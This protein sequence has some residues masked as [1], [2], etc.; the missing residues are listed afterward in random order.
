AGGAVVNRPEQ[1]GGL[2]EILERQ[3][4]E[5]RFAG[6]TAPHLLA[7]RGVV[8]VALADRVVEDG[9]VRRQTRDRELVDVAFERAGGQQ[10]PCDVGEPQPLAEFM[11]LLGGLHWR[12][13]IDF[14]IALA[15][16]RRESSR[17][18]NRR[19]RADPPTTSDGPIA[20][21]LQQPP[22]RARTRTCA[23]DP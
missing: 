5:Q 9:R 23:A 13:S 20:P 15:G 22:S 1:V 4:E 10:L 17:A 6:E 7:D 19:E 12:S 3:L 18:R 16:L 8:G 14:I 11:E 2:S 21:S